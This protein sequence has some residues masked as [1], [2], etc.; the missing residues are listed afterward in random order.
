[1]APTSRS[2]E[3][4]KILRGPYVRS[5][6][7]NAEVHQ[8]VQENSSILNTTRTL[9]TNNLMYSPDGSDVKR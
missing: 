9:T 7:Y 3:F 2:E 1:M 5:A 6:I 8:K 4:E